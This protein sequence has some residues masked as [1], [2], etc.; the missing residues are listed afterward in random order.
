V[1]TVFCLFV[2]D[3]MTVDHVIET[4][5]AAAAGVAA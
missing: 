3:V 4:L 1:R 2:G 5:N